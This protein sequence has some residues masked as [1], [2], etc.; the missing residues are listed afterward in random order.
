MPIRLILS[1][2]TLT[3]LALI[4]G[5]QQ[6]SELSRLRKESPF[7]RQPQDSPQ[8][9]LLVTCRVYRLQLP[10]HLDV[11]EMPFWKQH[12]PEDKKLADHNQPTGFS[13]DQIQIC[14]KNG[15]HIAIAPLSHWSQL[16]DE[17]I[18]AGGT[19][20]AETFSL[21]PDRATIARFPTFWLD[22]T[23]SVFVRDPNIAPRGLT[24]TPGD[25]AF[26][27]NCEPLDSGSPPQNLRVKIVPVF[28]S[29]AFQPPSFADQPTMPPRKEPVLIPFDRL[30]IRGVLPRGY[31]VALATR[32]QGRPARTLGEIFLSQR[33]A[34]DNLQMVLV[35]VPD[36]RTGSEVKTAG[37]AK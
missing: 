31:F 36:V 20:L 34:A 22:Q 13:T 21:F 9:I 16:R 35:L 3:G 18:D 24:L 30:T 32:P 28:H 11:T 4:T 14:R 15:L 10:G 27:V 37:S 25:C 6:E 8:E 17:I 19:G 29:A 23:T 5:C 2:L 1:L 26:W 12:D 7:V 33:Q